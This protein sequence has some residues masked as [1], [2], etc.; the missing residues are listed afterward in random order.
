MS[1]LKHSLASTN[2][3]G[4][5]YKLSQDS[6]SI[7][8]DLKKYCQ[9]PSFYFPGLNRNQAEAL[10][11]GHDNGVFLIRDSV[12]FRGRLTLSVVYNNNFEHYIIECNKFN[13]NLFTI[14]QKSWFNSINDLIRVSLT[15]FLIFKSA[16]FY[17][18]FLSIINF[19]R[20]TCRFS[21][22]LVY[23]AIIFITSPVSILT[24]GSSYQLMT[25]N[26]MN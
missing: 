13:R 22:Q 17:F 12:L 9:T 4:D 25:S 7:K 18:I 21:L 6:C 20:K 10:L 3:F 14:D 16:Y 19:T 15:F 2:S 24:K 11:S 26:S 1:C 5:N 23:L 8:N